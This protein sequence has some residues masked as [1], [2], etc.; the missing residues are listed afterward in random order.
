MGSAF[1]RPVYVMMKHPLKS[2]V[3]GVSKNT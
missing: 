2:F 1:A 3:L